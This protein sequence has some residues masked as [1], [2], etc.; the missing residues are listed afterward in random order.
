MLPPGPSMQLVRFCLHSD[1]TSLSLPAFRSIAMKS[2]SSLPE[3]CCF[4][5]SQAAAV[6]FAGHTA[7]AVRSNPRDQCTGTWS[8]CMLF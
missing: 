7:L 3:A 5:G 6:V 2:K 4:L 1:V 8:V